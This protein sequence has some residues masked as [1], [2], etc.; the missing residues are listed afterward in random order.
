LFFFDILFIICVC[1]LVI[2]F[3]RSTL[4]KVRRCYSTHSTNVENV[5]RFVSFHT[6]TYNFK[7]TIHYTSL[8][9]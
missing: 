8:C 9:I 7:Q 4:A 2:H 6:R 3:R 5:S 1:R